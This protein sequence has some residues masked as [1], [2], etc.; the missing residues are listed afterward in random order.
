VTYERVIDKDHVVSMLIHSASKEGKSTLSSTAPAPI[1]VIDAEG[2]WKF[3]D[4]IGYR[5]TKPLRKI[6]WN[7]V[8]EPVPRYDDT[9]DVAR[10]HVDS[11]Q[12]MVAIFQALT[13]YD[14]DFVSIVLDSITEIQRRCKANIRTGSAL[15]DQQRWGQLLDS[16]DGLIRGFRDLTLQP[17]TIRCV[18]F[19]CEMAMHNGQW[20]PFMQG[21]IRDTLPY[22]VD[23]CGVLYTEVEAGSEGNVKHKKLLIGAGINPAYVVGERVQGRLPDIIQEPN[24]ADM[25]AAIYPNR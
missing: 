19:N 12:T 5:G 15:M 23:I 25:L 13:Q 8:T 6:T 7:P 10:V 18:V 21:G 2:S 3:I 20:R 16:M 17:N 4:H 9:W 1:L 24:I 11:W 14:H 22:W